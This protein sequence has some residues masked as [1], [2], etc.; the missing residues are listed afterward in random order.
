MSGHKERETVSTAE[1]KDITSRRDIMIA[2][3]T[4]PLHPETQSRNILQ[5]L[6]YLHNTFRCLCGARVVLAVDL[7]KIIAPK[8][9]FRA[10]E[11]AI[12]ATGDGIQTGIAM[13]I[14]EY[15]LIQ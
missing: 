9:W 4:S 3:N 8:G 5:R 10:A 7:C 14:I 11:A 12:L 2:G 15:I 1:I 13:S 6:K